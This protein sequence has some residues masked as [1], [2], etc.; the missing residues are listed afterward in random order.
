MIYLKNNEINIEVNSESYFEELGVVLEVS[1]GIVT[2][3]GLYNVAFGE[4]IEII[5]PGSNPVVGIILNIETSQVSAVIFSSDIDIV[6]SYL[7]MRKYI[8]MSVPTGEA[9]LGRIMDPLGNTLDDLGIMAHKGF[10][11]IEQVAPSIISRS[12][13][14]TPLETGLKVVDSMVPIGHGQRELIIGDTKTGKTSI[15]IDAILNQKTED[16]ICVYVAIGQKR[17]SVVRIAKLLKNKECLN[18]TVIVAATASDSAAMQYIAPYSG[19]AIAEYFMSKGLRVLIIFDDLS[20][21]AVSYR[22]LSLLL[23]RPPGREGYPGD[24][25]F[26]HSR[27]LERS[28]NLKQGGSITALPI[29]ETIQGDVS[30]YVPTN[31]ISITDGQIFLETE[32]FSK[33]VRP[34]VSPGLSVSRVGSAAQNKVIK[35]MA[36]TL[37]LE[38]AQFREVEGFTKL[39]LVLDDATKNLV[40]KG[41]KLTSLLIQKRYAPLQIFEQ[42]LLLFA[43]LNDFLKR[44]SA[45]HINLFEIEFLNFFRNSIYY[46]PISRSLSIMK[47]PAIL[48]PFMLNKFVKEFMIYLN[49]NY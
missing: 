43:S 9:L 23:R 7:V 22:Q 14:N 32:L 10:R 1:D 47:F 4:M 49:L 28:A 37:K 13:V 44:V 26:L 41:S 16:T 45:N 39:G 18:S 29:I 17:S 35:N 19:C 46:Y 21:H 31:V 42:I 48:V 2:I 15:A 34:A 25:F 36:G 3:E 6:P 5:V 20:K 8:L 24:V 40:D 30:A 27:L 12:A 11:T 33:G 38:L